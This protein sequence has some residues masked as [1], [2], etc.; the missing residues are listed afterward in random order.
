MNDNPLNGNINIYS[1]CV[2]VLA[3][4]LLL[5]VTLKHTL[6]D[7]TM[8]FVDFTQRHFNLP[9]SC[10]DVVLTYMPVI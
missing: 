1:I 9:E 5:G 2:S 4:L 8:A 3:W 10:D 7:T 6:K